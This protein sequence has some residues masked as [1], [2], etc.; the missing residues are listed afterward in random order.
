MFNRHGASN[1]GQMG[2]A[3][4]AAVVTTFAAVR[5]PVIVQLSTYDV[6]NDNAQSDVEPVVTSGF[7]Q[8]LLQ[9]LALVKANN[10][11]MSLVYGRDVNWASSLASLPLRFKGWLSQ[12]TRPA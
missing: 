12:M 1:S 9:L 10:A 2:P 6:N 7:G 3:D 11:M 5:G 8:G 4:L